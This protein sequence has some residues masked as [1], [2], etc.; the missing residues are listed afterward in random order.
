MAFDKRE[1]FNAMMVIIPKT[2]GAQNHAYKGKPLL[3]LM[4]TNRMTIV[5]EISNLSALAW[6]SHF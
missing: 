2:L 3:E 6:Q 1:N 5:Q 4:D